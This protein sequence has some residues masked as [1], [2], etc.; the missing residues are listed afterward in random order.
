MKII[1]K[2]LV[3]LLVVLIIM[4]FFGPERNEGDSTTVDTFIAETNPSRVVKSILEN[5]C[6]D[7]HSDVT[8][9]PWYNKITP[10]NYWLA[11]HIEEGK[12]HF[13]LSA[14]DS[15]SVK[16][17]E[18]K[19]HELIEEVEEKKMPLE[20]YTY[21]HGDANLTDDQIA[22]VVAWGKEVRAKYQAQ[23]NKTE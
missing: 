16:R 21:T 4:Q 13:N 10:V 6:Y 3:A 18:H 2:I 9:Y 11:D 7:C 20:S 17:K 12:E 14:W 5:T 23:L 22:A 8:T 15:Y 1:K 19:M